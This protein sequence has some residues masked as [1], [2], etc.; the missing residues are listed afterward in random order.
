[1]AQSVTQLNQIGYNLSA[2]GSAPTTVFSGLGGLLGNGNY[3]YKVT[4]TTINGESLPS[5]ASIAGNPGTATGSCALTLI[6]T[7]N[8]FVTGRKLYRTTAGGSSFLLLSTIANNT[9]TTFNDIAAD[10]TLGAAA[11]TV[12]TANPPTTNNNAQTFTNPITLT[13]PA[14]QIVIQP[15]GSGNTLTLNGTQPGGASRIVNFPD[16]GASVNVA[17]NAVDNL[18]TVGQSISAQKP[19][20]SNTVGNLTLQGTAGVVTVAGTQ[21]NTSAAET[22]LFIGSTTVPALTTL[23]AFLGIPIA[24][25]TFQPGRVARMRLYGLYSTNGTTSTITINTYYNTSISSTKISTNSAASG[26]FVSAAGPFPFI[27]DIMFLMVDSTHL[28]CY[29]TGFF[30]E[31]N[32]ATTVSG[33][34]A[35]SSP[36]AGIVIVP[37]STSNIHVSWT[38]SASNAG[39]TAQLTAGVLEFLN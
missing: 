22:N 23:S 30:S 27:I 32:P 8:A 35:I 14:N 16:P 31:A 26:T 21:I 11:P 7:G 1:M 36:V 13:A 3:Q 25:A 6:P 9:T 15:G 5:A 2:P 29:G 33:S 39:N 4:F 38:F 17:Y 37:G 19:V 34:A 12:N 28:S 24:L 10:G 20:P 18:F